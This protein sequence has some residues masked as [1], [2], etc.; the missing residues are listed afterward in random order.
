MVEN[1]ALLLDLGDNIAV[2]L[3]ELEE[4]ALVQVQGQEEPVRILGRVPFGHKFALR[5]IPMGQPIVK[6]GQEI[7][8]SSQAIARGE[9]VHIHNLSSRRSR[10]DREAR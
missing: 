9:H 1:A 8:V 6:Y 4:G 7:G 10:G 3:V 2:A 5:D